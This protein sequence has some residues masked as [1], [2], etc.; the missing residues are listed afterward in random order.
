MFEVLQE[1]LDL[2]RAAHWDWNDCEFGAPGID[3]KRPWGFSGRYHASMAEVVGWVYD[4]DD[5]EQEDELLRL[6]RETMTVLM[7]C[8]DAGTLEPGLFERTDAGWR[9]LAGDP[10]AQTP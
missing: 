4:E 10:W 8:L 1:H 2:L 6:W 7:V 3:P 9:R 5:Q